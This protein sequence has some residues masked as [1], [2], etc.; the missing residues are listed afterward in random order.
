MNHADII[1][2]VREFDLAN[3]HKEEDLRIYVLRNYTIDSLEPY[4]KYHLSQVSLK[5][6][7]K[8]GPYDNILQEVLDPYSKLNNIKPDIIV[9]S[10]Y[11]DTFEP[12]YYRMEWDVEQTIERLKSLYGILHSNSNGI[13]AINTFIPPFH[14]E[15]GITATD[16]SDL[17]FKFSYLNQ[18][19]RRYCKTNP[20]R[21][22]LMD[23]ER[24]L[25][26]LGEKESLDYRY[27]YMSKSPFR[28]SFLDLYAQDISNIARAY[29]A[30][31]K[32]CI[33][34]D[35]DNTLWG[36]IVGEDGRDKIQL[37]PQTFPGSIYYDFQKSLLSLYHRGVMICLCSKNN[38]EDVWDVL[39]NHPHMLLKRE[40]LAG[41]KINWQDKAVNIINLIKELNI[42]LD[43]VVFVDDSDYEC[44]RVAESIP[45]VTVLQVPVD[46]SR[47]R[48]PSLLLSTGLFDTLLMTDED[49]QRAKMY[50]TEALRTR[51][52]Q[53]YTSLDEYL[54]SLHLKA[55]IHLMRDTEVQRVAQ[56]TQ[57]TN[58][59]NVT[60]R[61][62]TE[63][64]L[65][66]LID[67]G[68]AIYTLS[69]KDRYGDYGLT[70]VLIAIREEDTTRIDSLLLSCRVLGRNLEKVFIGYCL[71]MLDSKWK[72][73][74]MTSEY[75]R[76]SKN[77]QVSE[78]W[79]CFGF[80]VA[81]ENQYGK[82][83]IR[84]VDS[85][86]IFPEIDYIEILEG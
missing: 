75:I 37:D 9:L 13:I 44:G 8:L 65:E 82:R 69:V 30:L 47:Y 39:D 73:N 5:A 41:W 67:K 28:P 43:S 24:Y 62:Y 4:I 20:K 35:C 33:I 36:G 15:Y 38:E 71:R 54:S 18:E 3:N 78:L 58:Q 55:H 61:R 72:T 34:L 57:K 46:A 11:L 25:R 7:V 19:I 2:S 12:D 1:S 48:Y 49:Q 84:S 80:K 53:H 83:Y 63:Q 22:Y 6:S 10:L 29:K 52:Q 14:N 23:W 60:T 77:N 74:L 16:K 68:S 56:L 21:F 17:I 81:E 86:N 50:Q 45:E 76:T 79:D 32:K 26:L 31:N 51:E 59:F 85:K 70:G 40:H 66:E 42:G 64:Q 27:W